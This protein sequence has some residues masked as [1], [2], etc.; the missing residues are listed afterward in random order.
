MNDEI[1]TPSKIVI[2]CW[3]FDVWETALTFLIKPKHSDKSDGPYKN[4]QK[5]SFFEIFLTN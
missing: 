3:I 1:G 5:T 4:W 2:W